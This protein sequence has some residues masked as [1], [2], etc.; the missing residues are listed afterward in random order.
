[1]SRKKYQAGIQGL[2]IGIIAGTL[3]LTLHFSGAV[4]WL[5]HPIWDFCVRHRATPSSASDKI[6]TIVIDQHSL[7]QAEKVMGLTWKWPREIYA[8]ILS[9]CKRGGAKVVAFDMVFTERSDDSISDDEAFGNGIAAGPPCVVALPLSHKNAKL[10]PPWPT[11]APPCFNATKI[12]TRTPLLATN[13]T[14]PRAFF[15]VPQITSNVT[16]LANVDATPDS[17]AI[18]RSI[19][20]GRIY[21][22]HFVPTLGLAAY[23]AATPAAKIKVNPGQAIIDG[24]HI[25]I[26]N[27]GRAI[28]NFRGPSQTHQTL[29][30][31]VVLQSELRIREGGKPT[32]DPSILK[33]CYVFFGV[34]APG[35][36]DLK[37]TPVGRTY[38]GVE[39]HATMLDNLLANDFGKPPATWLVVLL[40]L[41]AGLLTGLAGRSCRNWQQTAI[42]FAIAGCLPP[43]AT[44]TVY[45]FQFPTGS[46]QVAATLSLLTALIVNYA[47]EGR[48]KRFIKGAF[49]QYLSPA[50]IDKLV[51]DPDRLQLGGEEKCLSIFFSDIQGFTS[52]SE[53]LSPTELTNLLNTYLTAMTDIIHEEGGTIDKYEGDAIIAFWNAPLEQDDHAVRAIRASLRCQ[54]KLK[55]MR[56]ELKTICGHDIY[57][58]I[59]INTGPVVVGNMG[60]D[61]RFD[62]TFLGDAGNLAARLEGINKQFGTYLMT[63]HF[64]VTVIKDA[65]HLRELSRVRVVGK[66]QPITVFEPFLPEDFDSRKADLETFNTALKLYYSG[67]FKTAAE[68][69]NTLDEAPAKI[70]AARCTKL[71][72]QPPPDWDGIWNITEK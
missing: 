12:F 32:L 11:Y 4:L 1:M 61:Q 55:S 25:P 52:V 57:A 6:C 34:S 18:F 15:P 29:N 16:M 33:D 50:V 38:P 35:L 40:T 60:S 49:K 48:Q 59:G 45:P 31:A 10:A 3:A 65:F 51:Q 7:N 56:P 8:A 27:Q 66:S 46:I 22:N 64:T 39:I 42:L 20:I 53:K 43:L 44:Y 58:R 47:V 71:A 17:D 67:K 62:Y 54:A 41:M 2:L 21:K 9:F 70:Y 36:M 30:A 28:L 19:N 14:M 72:E 69:F 5:D 26:D 23:L 24:H 68:I 63:S 13:I 37:P